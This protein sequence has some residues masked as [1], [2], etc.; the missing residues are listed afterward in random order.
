MG[1]EWCDIRSGKKINLTKK[2]FVHDKTLKGIRN[3][4]LDKRKVLRAPIKP[5]I[6]NVLVHRS[7]NYSV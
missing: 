2:N 3:G 6:M 5:T 1:N 7:I 4:Q